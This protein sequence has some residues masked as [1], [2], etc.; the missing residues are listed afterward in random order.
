MDGKHDLSAGGEPR[1]ALLGGLR[2]PADVHDSGEVPVHRVPLQP[3]RS[4]QE[5]DPLHPGHR[6]APGH[7]A[8][9][10][11]FSV[12]GIAEKVLWQ[13]WSVFPSPLRRD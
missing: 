5:V 10:N 7:P 11:A 12:Q 9:P 4:Q 1:H 2:P 13:E 3:L 6:L 8:D